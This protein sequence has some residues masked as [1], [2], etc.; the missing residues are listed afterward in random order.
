MKQRHPT[1]V[2]AVSSATLELESYLLS[3]QRVAWVEEASVDQV[4]GRPDACWRPCKPSLNTSSV[5]ILSYLQP[6]ETV[7]PNPEIHL[8]LSSATSVA[9]KSTMLEDVQQRSCRETADHWHSGAFF[10]GGIGSAQAVPSANNC[11]LYILRFFIFC[12][13]HYQQR[14]S[15]LPDTGSAFTILRKGTW[16][17][18]C[19]NGPPLE[20]STQTFVG[21]NGDNLDSHGSCE[22]RINIGGPHFDHRIFVLSNITTEALLGLDFLEAHDCTLAVEADELRFSGGKV[23]LDKAGNGCMPSP[24]KV[25][26]VAVTKVPAM[27]EMEVL[28]TPESPVL[29]GI[30]LVEG[31]ETVSSPVLIARAMVTAQAQQGIQTEG[32]L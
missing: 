23:P 2:E 10:H 16:E 30:W 27:S 4:G 8:P 22:L 1:T 28:A 19:P 18:I 31:R 5:W 24:T 32:F 29:D 6:V 25:L 11:I 26:R 17:Q 15:L 20:A 21:V 9:K 14:K 3:K 13:H 7:N 12:H